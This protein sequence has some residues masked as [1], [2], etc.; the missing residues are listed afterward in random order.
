MK[1]CIVKVASCD[2]MVMRGS[3]FRPNDREEVPFVGFVE[4]LM[5]MSMLYDDG[6]DPRASLD[7]RSFTKEPPPELGPVE[8]VV[9]EKPM[10]TFR[11]HVRF[12]QNASWQGTITWLEKKT[13]SS[14]RSVLELI[15]L[16]D[17]ALSVEQEK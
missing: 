8:P 13:Q 6:Q 10:A 14:F 17:S 3:V 12:K 1:V 7:L 4:L 16:M 9:V 15:H 2:N 11:V 5:R